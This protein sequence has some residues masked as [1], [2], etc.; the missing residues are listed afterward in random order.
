MATIITGIG[1]SKILTNLDTYNHTALNTSMYLVSV[2]VTEHPPSGLS[3][4]IQQNGTTKATAAAPASSQSHI[5]L[6]AILNC[7][8]SDTI[9]VVLSSSTP[10]DQML[11]KIKATLT[12]TQGSF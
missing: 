6:Q 10:L 2:A 12:I 9:S 8:A 1:Q 3:V 5:E 4:L 7:T 11:N